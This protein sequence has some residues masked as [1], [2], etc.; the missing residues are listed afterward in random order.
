MGLHG[1]RY[2]HVLVTCPLGW[3]CDAGAS[4]SIARL[5]TQ[6]GLF[7]VFEAEHGDVTDVTK[8]RRLVPVEE[9]LRPQ[10]RYA[11]LFK[12]ERRDDVIARVQARADRNIERFGLV[13]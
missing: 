10:K 7:P 6:C 11:H 9:Y 3:G 2:L 4:I 1:P 8:I 12:P 5:A 13:D